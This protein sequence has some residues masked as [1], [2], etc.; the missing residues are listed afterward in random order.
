[1]NDKCDNVT[2]VSVIKNS[3]YSRNSHTV[4][5]LITMIINLRS[6]ATC[7]CQSEQTYW[8]TPNEIK[9]AQRR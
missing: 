5:M 6:D 8:A 2:P 7:A 4:Y 9:K 1:M 3:T